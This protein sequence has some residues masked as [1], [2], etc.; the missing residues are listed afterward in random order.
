MM[1]EQAKTLRWRLR[2]RVGKRMRWYA[3][4]EEQFGGRTGDAALA[5]SGKA[6]CAAD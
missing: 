1:T 4:V 5:A 6:A 3:E 2:S